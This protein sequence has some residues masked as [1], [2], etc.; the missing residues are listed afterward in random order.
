MIPSIT[1][2]EMVEFTYPIP[3]V[4]R[5]PKGYDPVYGP[6]AEFER[7][8][9]TVR[10]ETDEGFAGK[11]YDAPSHELL[12]TCRDRLPTYASTYF[13]SLDGGLASSE[14]YAAFDGPLKP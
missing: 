8:T 3:E 10:I 11:Y 12:G 14:V 6:G 7:A 1:G 9:Y 13:G 2:L 4:R 5:N